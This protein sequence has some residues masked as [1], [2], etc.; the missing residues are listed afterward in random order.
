MIQIFNEYKS[1]LKDNEKINEAKNL[2]N[3]DEFS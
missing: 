2:D 3:F 1:F